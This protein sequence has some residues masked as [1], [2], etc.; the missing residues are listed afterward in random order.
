MRQAYFAVGCRAI[1]VLSQ[2]KDNSGLMRCMCKEIFY[3]GKIQLLFANVARAFA[4]RHLSVSWT[5]IS[6]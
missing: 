4:S 2:E 1:E 3:P 5:D 6:S